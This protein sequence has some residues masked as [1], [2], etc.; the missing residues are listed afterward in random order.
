M[1]QPELDTSDTFDI[2][3]PPPVATNQ[4]E[5]NFPLLNKLHSAAS[6]NTQP[7]AKEPLKNFSDHF[8]VPKE[9]QRAPIA[10]IPE[11]Q[12][13][14]QDSSEEKENIPA[15]VKS[16][17]SDSNSFAPTTRTETASASDNQTV[18]ILPASQPP[19]VLD[20]TDHKSAVV[21]SVYTS[22]DPC[23]N[24]F[25]QHTKTETSLAGSTR[26]KLSH[27][28]PDA[29]DTANHSPYGKPYLASVD[30]KIDA[31]VT[32]SAPLHHTHNSGLNADSA[33]IPDEI[34]VSER[35]I[36]ETAKSV[37]T[38]SVVSG[39]KSTP[40]VNQDKVYGAL[41]ESL[42][43]RSFTSEVLSSLSNPSP[44][45][46][47][48]IRHLE[49][50]LEPIMV[51]T[52]DECHTE[53]N[54]VY[55]RLSTSREFDSAVG[56]MDDAVGGYTDRIPT[57]RLSSSESS[58]FTS[59]QISSS[60][61]PH[62]DPDIHRRYLPSSL[63]SSSEPVD[64]SNV[65]YSE[66]THSLSEGKSNSFSL[67]RDTARSVPVVQISAPPVS[68][69]VTS[70]GA[71]TQVT[72]S[73]RRVILV[74]ELVTEEASG[75]PSPIP[76]E[77]STAKSLELEFETTAPPGEMDGL[78]G[79]LSPTYLSVGSDDGSAME[80]YYSAEEDNA[81]SGDEEMYSVDEREEMCVVDG[82]KEFVGLRKEFPQ[83][84]EF[85]ERRISKRGE[86][87]MRGVIVQKIVKEFKKD[88]GYSRTEVEQQLRGHSSE[89]QVQE[90]RM[91]EF[92]VRNDAKSQEKEEASTAFPQVKE[93]GQEERKEEL[94]A[95]PVQQVNTLMVCD[96]APP[97][98]E[99]HGQREGSEE[100]WAKELETEDHP[101]GEQQLPSQEI[102][103]LAYKDSRRSQFMHAAA[104][105]AREEDI[106]TPK[107]KE[108]EEQVSFTVE[109]NKRGEVSRECTETNSDAATSAVTDIP[110]GVEVVTGPLT[111]STE[112][113]SDATETEHNKA[114]EN[115]EWVD[116]ITQSADRI[117]TFP[118]QVT[119]EL[120]TTKTRRPRTEA[121]DALSES[122]ER[123]ARAQ[124]NTIQ[125]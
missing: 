83:Q 51:K 37:A 72:D 23:D 75:C 77:M 40:P 90:T 31:P 16:S 29:P 69:Y 39:E 105:N 100:N 87:E 6:I 82:L 89:A 5:S 49:T 63:H 96:F 28:Q 25:L 111:R 109:A 59:N 55:S 26:D 64:S 10:T 66:L 124:I 61:G 3:S 18:P 11:L 8:E 54:V 30:S 92:L 60:S 34:S 15:H 116:T 98:S 12:L 36:S 79:L 14:Y 81:E 112:L 103:Y 120:S 106:I 88:D 123:P 48:E 78:D 57:N 70:Q 13:D 74:K 107:S 58:R 102:E 50:K 32:D 97:S 110:G 91:S 99:S 67:I 95:T 56:K 47:T 104:R 121:A 80:I 71:D 33:S 94:P 20:T 86:G 27:H 21:D 7:E 93:E 115:S 42:F 62:R 76:E 45:I 1:S 65:P 85:A 9:T 73:I 35:S 4:F 125:G 117:G 108:A 119:V 113:Q 46:R 68:D 114:P 43:S 2:P 122:H 101:N 22:S 41:Y 38:T 24:D 118:Q 84:G 52:L 44:Q 19:V 17:K 53:R